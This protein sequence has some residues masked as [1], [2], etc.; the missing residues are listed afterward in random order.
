MIL[1]GDSGFGISL[2]KRYPTHKPIVAVLTLD[3]KSV[4]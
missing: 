3:R 2:I 1:E 4:V